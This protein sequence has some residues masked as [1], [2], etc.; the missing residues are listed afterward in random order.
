FPLAHGVPARVD[1]LKCLGNAVVP[2][3]IYPILNA[4]ARIENETNTH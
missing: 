2:Q 1:R 4:I 3:Q